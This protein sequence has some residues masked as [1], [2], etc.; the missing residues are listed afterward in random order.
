MCL[1]RREG[2]LLL[3]A[4][5]EGELRKLLQEKKELEER[6]TYFSVEFERLQKLIQNIKAELEDWK[7]RYAELERSQDNNAEIE[8]LKNQFEALKSMNL[9]CPLIKEPLVYPFY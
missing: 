4:E 7:L 8:N 6:A 2:L 5:M 1:Y 9:V 3:R